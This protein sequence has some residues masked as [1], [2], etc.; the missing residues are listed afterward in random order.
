M[1]DITKGMIKKVRCFPKKPIVKFH[2]VYDTPGGELHGKFLSIS[3]NIPL[4]S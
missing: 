3:G 4:I 2:H 1:L